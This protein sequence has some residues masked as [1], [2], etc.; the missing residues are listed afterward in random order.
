MATAAD[1][2]SI[3]DGPRC[4]RSQVFPLA[5]PVELGNRSSVAWYFIL[6]DSLIDHPAVKIPANIDDSAGLIEV[7]APGI[8]VVEL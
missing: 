2:S 5:T 1:Y 6:H 4:S 7:H 3:E 8:G